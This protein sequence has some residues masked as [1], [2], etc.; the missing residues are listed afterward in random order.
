MARALTPE[1]ITEIQ[2]MGNVSGTASRFTAAG[3]AFNPVTGES[4]RRGVNVI[5][6][7]VFWDLSRAQAKRIAQLTGSNLVFEAEDEAETAH[8]AAV[9]AEQER[10]HLATVAASGTMCRC[11]LHR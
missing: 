7:W 2:S 5:N 1:E 10:E 3:C 8:L 11:Y 4:M 6:S 9:K